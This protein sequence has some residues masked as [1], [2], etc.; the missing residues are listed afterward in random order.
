MSR[1]I[2]TE[3]TAMPERYYIPKTLENWKWPR[4]INPHRSEVEAESLAW[5]KSFNAFSPKAQD[6][7]DRCDFSTRSHVYSDQVLHSYKARPL[8]IAFVPV[9]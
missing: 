6:A 1:Q 7:F 9:V 4:R 5:M 3:D 2:H 8:R